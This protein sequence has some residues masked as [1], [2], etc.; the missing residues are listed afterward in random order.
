[1]VRGSCLLRLYLMVVRV[2]P[3]HGFSY[4]SKCHVHYCTSGRGRL[5]C[6]TVEIHINSAPSVKTMPYD[7]VWMSSLQ[8]NSLIPM[9]A[10]RDS[11][12]PWDTLCSDKKC[13]HG[14]CYCSSSHLEGVVACWF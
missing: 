13:C 14:L 2:I 3:I 4:V 11:C 7:H 6:A 10:C 12:D 9:H 1:M 8:L 5:L